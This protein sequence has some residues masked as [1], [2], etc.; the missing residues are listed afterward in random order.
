MTAIRS[1]VLARQPRRSATQREHF[2]YLCRWLMDLNGAISS[3]VQ[4]W[5][6]CQSFRK[7]L[8]S[9][10]CEFLLFSYSSVA[11]AERDHAAIQSTCSGNGFISVIARLCT[12]LQARICRTQLRAVLQ[13]PLLVRPLSKP[14]GKQE[15]PSTVPTV[16]A[17]DVKK[18]LPPHS[19]FG[20][21]AAALTSAVLLPG[22]P[23][24][25]AVRGPISARLLGEPLGH[26]GLQSLHQEGAR[27]TNRIGTP[28]LLVSCG[29]HSLDLRH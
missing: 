13:R 15:S 5:R 7:A 10:A 19:V 17:D 3:R 9:L 8:P 11:T 20:V 29:A 21:V 22:L 14:A 26:D 28:R 6:R 23:A 2:W 27:V 16:T 24:H 18:V 1:N 12:V 25:P 4:K